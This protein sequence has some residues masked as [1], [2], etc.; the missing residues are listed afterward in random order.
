MV[1]VS[2]SKPGNRE[3]GGGAPVAMSTTAV[4]NKVLL[5][6]VGGGDRT[7]RLEAITS[8]KALVPAY[9]D[10]SNALE[11]IAILEPDTPVGEAAR[12]ALTSSSVLFP[13]IETPFRVASSPFHILGTIGTGATGQVFR[14][15][16]VALR[17]LVAL[18]VATTNGGDESE[19][20]LKEVR[21]TALTIHPSL[22]I[23]FQAGVF[24]GV[25]FA[26]MEL[27]QGGS[28]ADQLADGPF[29][30]AK[31]LAVF[32]AIAGG[33]E[34]LH[35]HGEV[36]GEIH[37]DNVFPD[38]E[39]V[40]R[41]ADLGLG[42][43]TDAARGRPAYRP[44]EELLGEAADPRVDLYALGVLLFEMLTG[45]P[46]FRGATASE[47]ASLQLS[48][49][50][51]SLPD[52]LA[53]PPELANLLAR[54]TAKARRRRPDSCKELLAVLSLVL[55]GLSGVVSCPGQ[56]PVA[57]PADAAPC[58]QLEVPGPEARTIIVVDESPA[59]LQV[60]ASILQPA[61]FDVVS[62][63]EPIWVLALLRR[64]PIRVVVVPRAGAMG[65]LIRD[66]STD[67]PGV[68]VV[69]FGGEP[70]SYTGDDPLARA[71]AAMLSNPLQPEHV[72]AAVERAC[73]EIGRSL[74]LV[75]DARLVR[76]VVSQMFEN[77]AFRVRAVGSVDEAIEAIGT[78]LPD[79][80]LCDIQFKED[81]G[82]RLLKHLR[83]ACL[84]VPV[85]ILSGSPTVQEVIDAF[86][87]G[88]R[89]FIVKSSDP[90]PLIQ[91]VQATVRAS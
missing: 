51:P 43:N 68:Q 28:L 15:V 39:G 67:H 62:E 29:P 16:N 7:V 25:P 50:F 21:R 61:G 53:A 70:D 47:I 45:R 17:R 87:L 10:A 38:W 79:I 52:S 24:S 3:A 57:G 78:Q 14:A 49:P 86:R 56:A 8:L 1:E 63:T 31:A 40:P 82:L 73:G 19:R 37:P 60:I 64:R 89:D 12:R 44:P 71:A 59:V 72:V 34:A 54:L 6:L 75:D 30:V 69:A 23:V 5:D 9:P 26:A 27:P 83:G 76:L 77:L 4:L 46:P 20:F 88:A 58:A 48:E 18:R 66:L 2:T 85:I 11:A 84:K 80:I 35:Q 13:P 33:V 22:A 41:L 91:A 81:S 74:L 90:R 42:F 55:D 36:H 65:T 32:R